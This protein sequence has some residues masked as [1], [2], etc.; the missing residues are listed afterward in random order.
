[1]NVVKFSPFFRPGFGFEQMARM[2]NAVANEQDHRFPAYN[3]KTQ[4]EN[5]YR[6]TIAVPG[7]SA[8]DLDITLEGNALRVLGQVSTEDKGEN[9]GQA[10]GKTEGNQR[11]FLHRGI[12]EGSFERRFTL[13]DHIE[14]KEAELEN[15]MLH[16]DLVR[17][18]PEEKKP[19]KIAITAGNGQ[20]TIDA[21]AA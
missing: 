17:E 3:I 2:A 21:K 15:G 12:V 1:M 4:G 16:I 8:D 9:G 19:R 13:D 6:V 7:F 14:I 18:I 11:G 5:A 20:R 10:E